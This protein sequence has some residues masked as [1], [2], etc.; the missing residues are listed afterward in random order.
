M[1]NLRAIIGKRLRD[2]RKKAKLTQEAAAKKIG[3]HYTTLGKYELGEREPDFE[4]LQK[5]ADLYGI[6]IEDI[7][8]FGRPNRLEELRIT[9]NIPVEVLADRLD[10]T[11]KEYLLLEKM[12]QEIELSEAKLL[13]SFYNVTIDYLL[14]FNNPTQQNDLLLKESKTI[15]DPNTMIRLPVLGSIRA[16]EP[17]DLIE[18]NEGYTLV[19]P[20]VLNGAPGFALRVKGESMAGDNIHD[21]YVVVVRIQPEVLPTDIAVVSING[22]EA[23]LKRVKIVGDMAMLVPSNP[24]YEPLLVPAKDINIIGKVVEVKFWPK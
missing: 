12:G 2:A 5:L 6:K 14:G 17:N 10:I 15:Y 4:T 16:G 20:E 1:E 3:I 8:G 11:P 18:Y 24:E 7:V 9:H 21:G 22:E 19:D 13:A 23:T